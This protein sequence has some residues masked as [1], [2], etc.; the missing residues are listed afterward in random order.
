M[1]EINKLNK[2]QYFS[3]FNQVKSIFMHDLILAI[4]SNN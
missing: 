1:N 4:H 2:N 3:I